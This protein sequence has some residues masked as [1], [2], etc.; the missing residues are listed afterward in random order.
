MFHFFHY[1]IN[2][3]Q[4]K[5]NLIIVKTTK[6]LLSELKNLKIKLWLENNQ[7]RYK[8]PKGALTADLRIELVERKADIIQFL[9]DTQLDSEDEL[10]PIV[11]VS[12]NEKLPL[13]FAQQRLWFLNQLEGKSA[14][15]NMSA[16]ECLVGSLHISA[17]KQSLLEI[18]QRHEILRTTFPTVNG[19]PVIQLSAIH[20]Q[21]PIINLQDI[22]SEEQSVEIQRL[23]NEESRHSF[24]LSKDPLFRTTLLQLNDE[25]HILLVNMHHIISD[26]WSIGVFIRELVTLYEAFSKDEPSPLRPLTIQYADFA[27]WQRQW[28]TGEMLQTQIDY[29]QQQLADIPARLE[30]PTDYPR[31]PIQTFKGHTQL[32]E[33]Q[34]E[35]LTQLNQLSQEAN[36]T[37]FMSLLAAYAILLGRYSGTE[38]VVIGSP[39]ANRHFANTES[40]IG[41]FVNTLVLRT[42][43]SG[44]PCFIDLLAQVKQTCLGAYAHQ[45]V[46][47]EQLV[48]TLKPE[49]NLSHTPL[50]QVMFVLQNT[51]EENLALSGLSL[52]PLELDNVTAKFDLTLSMEE[53]AQGMS[54][55]LE[56]NTD[57]FN[58]DTITRM[59]DHFETLLQG[60]VAAPTQPIAELPL[61]T[62]IEKHQ[63]LVEWNNTATTYPQT[64]YLHQLFE[65]QVEKTPNAI[66]VVFENQQLTYQELNKR[67]NQLAHYLQTLGVKPEVLVGI[68]IERSLEMVIGLLGILK[69]GGAYVPVDPTYPQERIAFVLEDSNAS[70]L[71]TQEKLKAKLLEL[72]EAKVIC[73]ETEW[74]VISQ[75]NQENPVSH[76]NSSNLAYVIYTS[77]ST[78]KPK[79]VAIEHH[80]TVVLL[81]W[82]TE[83]FTP[84]QLSG[85]LA[86]TSICFDLSIFELFVPLSWGGTIILVKDALHLPTISEKPEVTLINTVPSAIAELVRMDAIPASVKVVNLAGEA[87]KNDLVQ[88]IYQIDTVQQVFNLYGPSE[89]TTYSTFTLTRRGN[90]EL[91][92]I[93]HPIAN[94][95]IYIL[96][97]LM[98]PTPLGVPGELHIGGA[99]LARGYLNRPKLTAEKFIK[100]PFS[101]NPESRL[102]KT[103]DLAR[104]LSDGQIEYLGRIDNQVKLR[105]F[106]IELGEIETVLA[107]H[108]SVQTGVVIVHEEQSHDKR[109]IAYLVPNPQQ[110][111]EKTEL[112]RFLKE[113]LPDYMVPSAF[114]QIDA[115]PLT[116][117]GKV[118]RRALSQLS[119]DNYQFSSEKS[120]V[121]PRTPDEE[122]L[123]GVWASV[124][125]VEQVGIFDN[126]FE[127]GGHSLL[128]T[129][130]MSRIR[131]TFDVELPLRHLFESPTVAELSEQLRITRYNNPNK[132]APLSITPVDRSKK[133][134]L[135]FAQERLWFL[136]Q[137]TPDNPFY[138]MPAAVRLRGPLKIAVLEQSLSEIIQRHET[139]RTCFPMKNGRPIQVI[140]SLS[141][142]NYYLPTINLQTLLVD[143]QSLEVQR[144]VT[145]E[146]QRPFNLK[147]GPLFRSTLLK[148]HAEEH[149]L[150]VTIHHIVNDGWS[151]GVL[152]HELS[153]L[154]KAY[155]TGKP[156][157]LIELPIQYADFAH[158]QRQ[159]LTGKV[160]ETQLSYW[161]QQLVNAPQLLEMPTDR[162]R[163]PVHT[164]QGASED[165]ELTPELTQQLK[166]LSQQTGV[167]L[168]MTSLAAFALLLSRY[169]GQ[170]EIVIGSPIA[171]RTRQEVEPLI[172]FFVNTL[173][174]RIDLSGHPTFLELLKRIRKVTLEAYAHQDLPFEQLVEI[175]KPER[176]MSRNPL[177]Q[178]A[179]AFQN[180]PMPPL[181]LP[182]LTLSPVEFEGGTVRFD[183]EFHLWEASGQLVGNLDYYKDLFDA[184]TIIRLLGHFQ[185]LLANLAANP[186]LPIVEHSLLSEAERH[187]LL[188]EWNNTKTDYPQD[189]CIHQLFE[190]QVEKSPE[191]IAVIFEN[192]Q[193][194]YRELNNKANQL[195][196]YLQTLG[197]KPEVLVGICLERSL[198]MVIGL[199]GILKAE[200][201]YVP[202]DPAYPEARLA[203]MLEDADVPVLLSQSSLVDKLP[204]TKAQVVCLDTEAKRLS[205]LSVNNL[206]SEAAPLNLA[207]VIYTSGSTGQPKGVL[208]PH[209]GL[210][211][212]VFWHQRTFEV[213]AQDYATQ[214]ASIAFDASVWELW[215]YLIAG[216]R[217]FLIDS[218]TIKSPIT[219]QNWLVSKK[220]T[221]TFLPTP[222]AEELLFLEWP[223]DIALRMMLTGGDK[224]HGSPIPSI[225]FK[226]VNNYGPTENTVVTT[227]GIVVNKAENRL[228]PIGFPIANTQVYVLDNHLQPVSIGIPGELYICG[229]GLARGYLNRPEL[230]VKKFIPNP[231]SDD[232]GNRLYKTGDLARYLPNGNIEYLD[233]IDNQVKIR[234]FRIELGEIEAVLTQH[235]LVRETVVTCIERQPNNK[236][237][238][239]Y[240]VY[241]LDAPVDILDNLI[242]ESNV[243]QISQ[244]EHIFD[245]NYGQLDKEQDS[246]F[247][248]TGWN[249]S[250]TSLP[251]PTEE[252]REWV[253]STVNLI[254]SLQP[255][256][257]LEIGCGT[258]LLLSRIAP[259]C[260]QYCGTD[261]SP[262]VLQQVEQLKRTI[263]HLDHVVLYNRQADD[264]NNIEPATF[265]TIIIN[266]VIQYFPS[267]TYLIDVLDKAIKVVKP[268]G[269]LFIGDVRS[270]PLLKAY[271]ASVQFYQAA[272]SFSQLKLQQRVQQHIRQE[273]ELVIDPTFFIALKQH[274]PR[275]T[276]VKIQPK[277]GHYHNELTR[278]RYD[279]IL[280]IDAPVFT[281]DVEIMWQDWQ[282]HPFTLSTLRQQLRENSLGMFGW[283]NVPNARIETEMKILEWLDNATPTGTVAQLRERLS[284][285][286]PEGI[287]PE[288][289]WTLSDELLY[290]IEM[291]WANAS[292]DGSYS[293]LF[294]SRAC[295]E[296]EQLPLLVD[297]LPFINEPL[298]KPLYHYANNPLQSKQNRQL[299]PQLRQFLQNQLPEYMVPPAFVMLEAIPLLPNG[300]I[301]YRALPAQ[302]PTSSE[303]SS[304]F[305][306]PRTLE[307]EVL[308]GILTEVL[309]LEQVGI[310]DNFFELG[311]DSIRS[312][313]VL[314]K[315]KEVGIK[316]SLQQLFQSQTIYE[317]ARLIRYQAEDSS[318]FLQKTEAFGLISKEERWK[319]PDKIEDAYPLS[320]LQAGML[321]H[322]EYNSERILYHDVY[323]YYLKTRLNLHILHQ[324]I[325]WLVNRHPVLRTSFAITGFKE[326]LQLVHQTVEVPLPIEDW[327]HLSDAEQEAALTAWIEAEKKRPFDWSHPPLRFQIH[328]RTTDTFNLTL[329]FHHAIFDGW[330]L[331]LLLTELFQHYFALLNQE[332]DVNVQPP[333]TIAFRDFIAL[334]RLTLESEQCRQHWLKTLNNLTFLKVPR[335]PAFYRPS[336]GTQTDAL[337]VLLS[338]EISQG[339]KQLA[340]VASVPLKSVLLAAHL[341][342]LSVLG[343]QTDILTGLISNGRPEEQGGEQLLG[344][345]LNTLP[346]RLQMLG[347]TWIDLV[348]ETFK[349]ELE[350]I[351]Y[352]RFPLAELQ[353]MMGGTPLFETVFNF[354]HFH[355]YQEI[356]GHEGIEILGE[357]AVG[358]TNF[359]LAADFSLDILS[360]RVN[361]MLEYDVN[362]LCEEQIVAIS[363]YYTEALS[364]IASQPSQRYENHSLLLPSEREQLLVDWNDTY[365]DYSHDNSCIHQLFEAQ[366]ERTP[367]AIALVF[368]S[369]QLTYQALNTKANQLAY[370]LQILGVKPEVL[371]GI[372][373]ERSLEMII[374]LLGILKAGGAY[375]PLD[376]SYPQERLIFMLTDSQLSVLLTQ[377]KFM[378]K[379]P[380]SQVQIVCLDTNWEMFS[381]NSPKNLVS[382]VQANNLAY[383][384]Y[385]SGSTGQPKGVL[386]THQGLCSLAHAQI[387]CFDVQS[388]SC[389]LQFAS[390]SFDASIS[391]IVMSLCSGAKL[392][393]VRSD[394]LIS[395]SSLTQ[396]LREQ[397]ITHITLPPSTLAVLPQEELLDLQ[398][399]IVA[400]EICSANLSAQWSQ[401]RRLFN[402]YGPTES[403]VCA[404]IWQYTD[405]QNMSIGCPIA[406]TQIYILNNYLQPVPVGVPG[407]LHIGGIGLA[408]GYFNRPELTVEKFIPNSFSN[409]P[410]A[411]L[412]KT[413]DLARYLPDGNIEF[414][415]RID[416]QV[417]IR[418]FRVELGEIEAVLS[419]HPSVRETVV[420]T[421]KDPLENQRL[422]AYIVPYQKQGPTVSQLQS[423]LKVKLPNYMVPAAWV[424]LEAL[425]LTPNGKVDRRTLP[426]PENLRPQLETAY[427]GPQTKMEHD[428]TAIWQ[429]VLPL[430]KIGIYDNFFDVG[431][432]S[433]LM[434]QIHSQ[435][436]DFLGQELSMVEIFKYPTIHAL[437]KYL[438]HKQS[439]VTDSQ[440]NHAQ[441]KRRRVSNTAMQQE[442]LRRQ[443]H[444]KNNHKS[445]K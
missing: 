7:L 159:W 15:Y 240:V 422:V 182:D 247:N 246:T 152:I 23:V 377:E 174:L 314:A 358:E 383:M 210:L 193:L 153:T 264:F 277:R 324:A 354:T 32:F 232:Q 413:G 329:S 160:L 225:S 19:E 1:S 3:Q 434:L 428:I 257:V 401:G 233:R 304:V 83:V 359:T 92:T 347:G 369:A 438:S 392:C 165:F 371:V 327:C 11:A 343:N 288:E 166:S 291:S 317:L 194:T 112:C 102:Y 30:L 220:I 229:A 301:D 395:G 35:L 346:F 415:G 309:G 421:L 255:K 310:H 131:D 402:A 280:Q 394:F 393:L 384:I 252:M 84:K 61:L 90:G 52:S 390:L 25:S 46:P 322:S 410:D 158:W 31:P 380:P 253:D 105:G 50:F 237:L 397:A 289:L 431:G 26:G 268:G 139:L 89:D 417:K 215:P 217:I 80:N 391:E 426:I 156:S 263:N 10:P 437:A 4:T 146:A 188:V 271:H 5:K 223:K 163:P 21:L 337:N 278:F 407:E 127:L 157:P 20:Y 388:Q 63:I 172:G 259:H 204:E 109:L 378:A 202:L 76:V 341:K 348:R 69:A 387:Q 287:D 279:V 113:K 356:L 423:F 290:D 148:L 199:L 36:A 197:V 173:V 110:L 144:I 403:T 249:S 283:R 104:Y 292:V 13:S 85:V 221:L 305:V 65:A 267:V 418:G 95:Q 98:Q 24:D 325:Q 335:W 216:S 228:P 75:A 339:L 256:S 185:T 303:L 138:N 37:L 297:Q 206:N 414:L 293:I 405:N 276:H 17:L 57:L 274:N 342:V 129:Q 294:K 136:D 211:N 302:F 435:L 379:L 207:Y 273:E 179:L 213:T 111:I 234:G 171:N 433:L 66:A 432:H 364:A 27:H 162:P 381:K 121:A 53:T 328:H 420:I 161:Q 81:N 386:I 398:H 28:L 218:E 344:L 306:A 107:Q 180:A 320:A 312:I 150:I 41:F 196:H 191:A 336:K 126:F 6:K 258:G 118:N 132:L 47:F 272:D 169:T 440:Q 147:R 409:D 62:E 427:V 270:L 167:T 128:A 60:I 363:G 352:R 429:K 120:F 209:Q 97:H 241:D 9:A 307:E 100:N 298:Y 316:F 108:P 219:L 14:T 117:N 122:L 78:G 266:S 16:A 208:V 205:Q 400:G 286:Q 70:I 262:V 439:Q 230:T 323:S 436:R 357:Q 326:P 140:H 200:G 245:K 315:A 175:L 119:V 187:Q 269:Y 123:V 353:R 67:A 396:R 186:K 71:L 442:R 142:T 412:Y 235:P 224:L 91:V 125:K 115:I 8:A 133:L 331:A 56:Y 300:K 38:D 370:H 295:S 141:E 411:R 308:A 134:L 408:R 177:V 265:D 244:W 178:V 313:Q 45:D 281:T 198:E 350:Y 243:G 441:P 261:F 250:Y 170:E 385:T 368:E 260:T 404:S 164:F 135:S 367:E 2:D 365:V 318:L 299:V 59:V 96:D 419:Q 34:K 29:W 349:T 275:L 425:P 176:D 248:I 445:K 18:A 382:G 284:K 430:E 42:N 77:G 39:I 22:P 114:V 143:E 145:E 151:I 376:P 360:D 55:S 242:Q 93:G 33:I 99:G 137:L 64:Q 74:Q 406:N 424:M 149:I 214:L 334:E 49:R 285:H 296:S 68:C 88:Q 44:N 201:A 239:A 333:F 73:L 101:N 330:S 355:V 389:I 181:E 54:S 51:P 195:A 226:L 86:S 374:G 106:R 192:Q 311:G 443:K 72:V 227:S 58:A 351:P 189:K 251:I 203:F 282:T 321:F 319:L 236:Q 87:L 155:A 130:V 12:R 79:G 212:L 124:L 154:Y 373:V 103:G 183:L 40:L 372:H 332:I 43:L 190:E 94:T 399:M 168:F 366:V 238:M 116:P 338:A 82:A 254:C 184:A 48:E 340:L 231:F 444:R 345:F 375:V 416:N 362:E 222:L 361:L